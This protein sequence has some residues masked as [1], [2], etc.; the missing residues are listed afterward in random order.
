[1]V[2]I[3]RSFKISRDP[4]ANGSNMYKKKTIT[5]EPGVTVLVGCNGCGK[6]TLLNYIRMELDSKKIPNVYFNN[7]HDGGANAR[8][9]AAF[10]GDFEF[11]GVSFNSSEG[12]NIVMNM[13]KTAAKIGRMVQLYCNDKDTNEM[14][15]LL[16]AIDSGLSIDNIVDVKKYL[17]DVVLK[18]ARTQGKEVYIIVSANEYEMANGESCFDVQNSKYRVFKTYDA[19]RKYILKSK[20][21][22]DLRDHPERAIRERKTR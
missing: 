13:G 20:E 18:D 15:V 16:D 22:K 7:L 19:Y 11:V 4:Y 14:W 9:S 12:E 17:F 6:T 21:L 3:S 2:I 1:M 5:I 10:H 8:S